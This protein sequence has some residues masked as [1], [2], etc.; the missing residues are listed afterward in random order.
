MSEYDHWNDP[1]VL[2]P[3]G[4]PLVVLVGH[5]P[6]AQDVVRCE[7]TAHVIEK[8]RVFTYIDL[9]GRE[10]VGRYPWTYP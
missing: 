3:V 6:G 5:C 1:N 8:H 4:C 9:S 10:F 2:P 7:R